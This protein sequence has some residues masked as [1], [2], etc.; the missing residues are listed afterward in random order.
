[1][2]KLEF[3][4]NDIAP[5]KMQ[6]GVKLSTMKGGIT[7]AYVG[8]AIMN[9]IVYAF[10]TFAQISFGIV[11]DISGAGD[12]ILQGIIYFACAYVMFLLTMSIGSERAKRQDEFIKSKEKY[13]ES[14]DQLIKNH[15]T[16][17]NEF[18]E[19]YVKNELQ[20][21]RA[22]ALTEISMEYAEYEEKYLGKTRKDLQKIKL[23]KHEIRVIIQA[24]KITPV[25]LESW[26]ITR[27]RKVSA[28]RIA[29]A[30]SA[31]EKRAIDSKVHF[32]ISLV[33]TMAASFAVVNISSAFSIELLILAL[34]RL[35]P[36]IINIPLGLIRG[37]SLYSV[38]EIT[39]FE[40]LCTLIESANVYFS[41][42]QEEIKE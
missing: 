35:V 22:N 26:M 18:C 8:G 13:E 4:M 30:P 33:T 12:L 24:N 3:D 1:M 37:Y 6:A 15:G 2:D 27:S 7:S 19:W 40:S 25:K 20:A 31:Q 32:G 28:H 34:V 16:K 23:S 21:A 42:S 39:N 17:I 5:K 11:D 14:R 41:E 38:R 36:F 10:V 29:V 9:F